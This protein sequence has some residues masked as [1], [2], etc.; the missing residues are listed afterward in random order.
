MNRNWSLRHNI[1]TQTL[2]FPRPPI[3]VGVGKFRH[4]LH[5]HHY[6]NQTLEKKIEKT[7]QNY[8]ERE[9]LKKS[10]ERKFQQQGREGERE[11]QGENDNW[12]LVEEG[13]TLRH[14]KPKRMSIVG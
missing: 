5:L 3:H 12:G 14:R 13:L 7:M 10:R 8:S 2:P 4:A 11:R 1:P 9:S 6:K